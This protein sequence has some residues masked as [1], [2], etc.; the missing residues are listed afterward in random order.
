MK[1]DVRVVL[2]GFAIVL[3]MSLTLR[4]WSDSPNES[5]T[6]EAKTPVAELTVD[7][8]RRQAK[9]LHSTYE[10]TLH[11]VHREYFQEGGRTPIPAR[12]LEDIFYWVDEE[13]QGETRWIAVNTEAM[14]ID[15]NPESEF[16]KQAAKVLATGEEEFEQIDDGMY[17]RAGAITLFAS[18]LKCHESSLTQLRTKRR[19]AGLVINIPVK[20][21]SAKNTPAKND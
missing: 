12:V 17:R 13:T 9:L 2:V 21:A 11:T 1:V 5:D 20:Q 15:H 19:V 8:A 4:V 3:N 18:C 14:S 6:K 10:S 7:E 16:E